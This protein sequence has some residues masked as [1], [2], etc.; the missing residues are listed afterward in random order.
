MF[1]KD[2]ILH[3]KRLFPKDSCKRAIDFFEKNPERHRDSGFNHVKK[4][5][6]LGIFSRPSEIVF[7]LISPLLKEVQ[8]E[9]METYPLLKICAKWNVNDDFK[10]QKY[11]P[12]ESYFTLH[13]ENMGNHGKFEEHRRVLA[14]MIYLNDVYDG[15]YTEFPVQNKKFQPR[16]GDVLV[17][18]AY[19]THPHRGVMSK[20][21]T[22]YIIT[23][24]F[25]FKKD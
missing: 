10:I 20:K 21:D 5:T 12:G 22:K 1:S 25:S 2:H 6:E 23:G 14:W 11:N 13:A 8:I 4:F 18:P 24:W 16:E 17:W 3:K 7:N 19:F 9:Y 15:G